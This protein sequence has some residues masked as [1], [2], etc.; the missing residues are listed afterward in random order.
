MMNTPVV[1]VEAAVV[2]AADDRCFLRHSYFLLDQRAMVHAP[3][4]RRWPSWVCGPSHRIE[5]KPSS[6]IR[7]VPPPNS[8]L[9]QTLPPRTTIATAIATVPHDNST[10]TCSFIGA[11][12]FFL[13]LFSLVYLQLSFTFQPLT[14]IVGANGC[15]KTTIMLAFP[16][17]SIILFFAI[18]YFT[19]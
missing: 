15:G 6:S 13:F 2:A 11:F 8:P 17:I 4:Y 10:F 1:E 3:R 18:H 16:Y 7:S 5:N 9:P 19:Y 14:M 12:S